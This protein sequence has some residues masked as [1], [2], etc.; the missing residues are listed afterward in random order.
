MVRLLGRVEIGLVTLP[1]VRVRD[2]VI[3]VDMARL[4]WFREVRSGERKLR[5]RVIEG[6]GLPRLRVVAGHAVMGEL[7][8][9]VVRLLRGA[10]ISYNFV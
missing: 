7:R 10:V 1:A 3:T 8:S 4:A 5:R 6:R 9:H 2:V